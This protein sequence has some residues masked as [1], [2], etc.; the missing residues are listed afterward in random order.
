[1]IIILINI[2]H[3]SD[4][5]TLAELKTGSKAVVDEFIGS[6]PSLHRIMQLGLLEGTQVEVVRKAISGDPIEVR[7]MGYSLSLRKNEANMIR[8]KD[9]I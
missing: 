8:V 5:M 9:I 2:L 3:E 1:M 7:L 6:G 4:S